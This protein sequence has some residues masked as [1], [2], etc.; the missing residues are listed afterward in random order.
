MNQISNVTTQ[1]SLR[2]RRMKKK[3]NPPTRTAF[4]DLTQRTHTW[5]TTLFTVMYNAHYLWLLWYAIHSN[6]PR[7]ALA[8]LQHAQLSVHKKKPLDALSPAHP[9]RSLLLQWDLCNVSSI[10]FTNKV[11]QVQAKVNTAP[12][13]W[14][15]HNNKSV[16][17]DSFQKDFSTFSLLNRKTDARHHTKWKVC[18]KL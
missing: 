11:L 6:N 4:T 15:A 13:K 8:E 9:H 2:E 3:T 14:T 12:P 1:T 7:T 5:K 10:H 17:H 16:Q 18:P